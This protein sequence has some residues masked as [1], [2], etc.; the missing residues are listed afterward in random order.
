MHLISLG[1]DIWEGLPGI[2]N[3]SISYTVEEYPSANEQVI[4]W[5]KMNLMWFWIMVTLINDALLIELKKLLVSVS[6]SVLPYW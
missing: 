6:L 5:L 2:T 1:P 3:I 4:F